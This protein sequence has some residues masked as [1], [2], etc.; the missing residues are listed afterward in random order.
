[1]EFF[2]NPC[3]SLVQFLICFSTSVILALVPRFY[4]EGHKRLLKFYLGFFHWCITLAVLTTL[5]ACRDLSLV[6]S[7]LDSHPLPARMLNAR[8]IFLDQGKNG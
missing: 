6:S 5:Q 2:K 7:G 3:E 4:G 1:M 8:A